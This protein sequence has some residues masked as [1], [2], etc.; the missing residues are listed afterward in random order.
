M[1][2]LALSTTIRLSMSPTLNADDDFLGNSGIYSSPSRASLGKGK[3]SVINYIYP[4]ATRQV[5]YEY[6]LLTNIPCNMLSVGDTIEKRS[7]VKYIQRFS[8]LL[9]CRCFVDDETPFMALLMP[10]FMRVYPYGCMYS[11]HILEGVCVCVH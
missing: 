2:S 4:H 5:T 8:R 10:P 7:A 9:L 3:S 6:I 11:N 1:P